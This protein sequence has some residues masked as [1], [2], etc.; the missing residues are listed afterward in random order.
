M[1]VTFQ[2]RPEWL[3]GYPQVKRVAIGGCALG[4]R[5]QP[6]H[7]AHA[8]TDSGLVCILETAQWTA[9]APSPTFLHEVGHLLTGQGHTPFWAQAYAR[10]LEAAG[11]EVSRGGRWES[12]GWAMSQWGMTAVDFNN[13]DRHQLRLSIR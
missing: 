8:H 2:P 7:Q 5:T 3:A 11:Y 13:L 12:P 1:G 4:Y 10:L 6:G 9:D